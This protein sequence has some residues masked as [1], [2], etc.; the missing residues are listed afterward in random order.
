MGYHF[1]NEAI[2]LFYGFNCSS[3]FV[4]LHPKTIYI[5]MQPSIT[6]TAMF[7][8]LI[9]GVIFSVNFLF[10]VSKIT[11]L[12]LLT[13]MMAVFIVV[14]MYRMTI[15][16]RDTECKGIITYWKAFSFILLTFFFA[17]I[18][19]SVVKY[20]YFQYINPGY[21][22]EMFQETMKLLNSMKFPI[23]DAMIDQ[24]KS[25][26]KPVSYTFVFIWTNVFMGLIVGL[27]MA[28]FVRKEKSVFEE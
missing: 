6:K 17:A 12:V 24:T 15:R 1:H 7:N 21:L 8:G 28:A 18:I 2:N 26:L 11:T 13:N 14:G 19:S 10:S 23:N 27:I 25:M 3:F 5:F 16:F 9:M 22:D 4:L 20:V